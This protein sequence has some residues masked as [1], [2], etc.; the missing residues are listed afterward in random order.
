V[1]ASAQ[2]FDIEWKSLSPRLCRT[3]AARGVPVSVRDDIVQETGMRLLRNWSGLDKDRPLWPLTL[4]IATNLIKDSIRN[5]ERRMEM[6][7]DPV[8]EQA[9]DY[10][11]EDVVV[12]R[13]ELRRI[14]RALHDLTDAQRNALLA[15]IG[16]RAP[17]GS[18]AAAKML[19]M[20]A[21]KQL[22]VVLERAHGFAAGVG[23]TARG[24]GRRAQAFVARH[25][26]SLEGNAAAG[27][28]AI[29]V[30][31][32]LVFTPSGGAEPSSPLEQQPDSATG[33]PIRLAA[34]TQGAEGLPP[35]MEAVAARKG[36]SWAPVGRLGRQAPNEQA[37]NSFNPLGLGKT[38][39]QGGGGQ[40]WFGRRGFH[41]EGGVVDLQAD[42]EQLVSSRYE[43]GYRTSPCVRDASSGT[44]P[45]PGSCTNTGRAY[46]R[47]KGKAA[48]ERFSVEHDTKD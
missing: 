16:L 48:G 38:E 41:S 7:S 37:D 3:L 8:P 32:A 2:S 9:L 39:A 45:A 24:W 27:M 20:R 33:V 15:E 40:A 34:A 44:A 22:R 14:E 29:C 5:A 28:V 35:G 46:V 25:S 31:S 10:D 12:A 17:L 26:S 1:T 43:A 13:S 36:S 4:T 23:L 11:V 19:R 21:R 6:A 42:G 47:V 30:A 18:S